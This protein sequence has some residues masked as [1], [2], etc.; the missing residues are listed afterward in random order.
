MTKKTPD[1]FADRARYDA[2]VDAITE[3]MTKHGP[4]EQLT[5]YLSECIANRGRC[6]RELSERFARRGRN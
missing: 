6:E 3:K 5:A 2:E 4:T 1:L